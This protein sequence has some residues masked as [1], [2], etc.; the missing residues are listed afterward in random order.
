MKSKLLTLSISRLLAVSTGRALDSKAI[1]NRGTRNVELPLK[2]GGSVCDFDTSTMCRGYDSLIL[3]Q[4]FGK[5]QATI[6]ITNNFNNEAFTDC[7]FICYF[8][9]RVSA[10]AFSK[11]DIGKTIDVGD[12]ADVV[13]LCKQSKQLCRKGIH[14][15]IEKNNPDFIINLIK[16]TNQANKSTLVYFIVMHQTQQSKKSL[17]KSPFLKTYWCL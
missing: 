12:L 5:R 3:F 7:H 14:Y 4:Y 6:S 13:K 2:T 1:L 16:E 9:E 8:C 17:R 11:T 10:S 15:A